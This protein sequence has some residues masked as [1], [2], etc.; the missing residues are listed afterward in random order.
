MAEEVGGIVYEVGMDVKGLKAGATTAN[1]TLDDLESSTNKTTSA[2][3]KLDKNARNAGSGMKNAGGAASGLKTSMSMLAGAISVSLI[4]EWGKRFLEVAD[5]MTQ[6]QA[7][8]ARLSTD[9]KTAN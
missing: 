5:N 3:G 8:I 7:R 1:K 9:A 2:L 6:L 4:I